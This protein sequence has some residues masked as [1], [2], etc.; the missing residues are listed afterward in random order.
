MLNIEA[1]QS[2]GV[3]GDYS[4]QN[5]IPG[6]AVVVNFLAPGLEAAIREAI[7]KPTEDIYDT[8]LSGLTILDASEQDIVNLNGIQ[9][10][11]DL[12]WLALTDNQIVDISPLSSLTNLTELYLYDNQIVDISALSSLTNLTELYLYLNQIVDIS[13]LSNFTNLTE[14]VLADNQIVDI[15][16]L[17]NLANLTTLWLDI[18]QIVDISSLSGLTNLTTLGLASNQIAD[19][20]ALLNNAGLGAGADVSL[21]YNYLDL[22]S[23]SPDMLVIEALQRRG[24]NVDYIPQNWR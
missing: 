2:R 21:A 24:V 14:L 16:P 13:P 19:I 17:S 15:S 6:S 8:D 23:G 11:V 10:C 22:K 3:N 12:T 18:N 9:Y 1:L 5:P 4:P 20:S 7:G